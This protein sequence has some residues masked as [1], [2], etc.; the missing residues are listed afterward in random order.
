MFI[1]VSQAT[2]VTFTEISTFL[3]Y[4]PD[5]IYKYKSITTL[6]NKTITL[7]GGHLVY[8]RKSSDC[9]FNTV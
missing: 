6:W 8:T 5:A 7:T 4:T 1:V 3:K 2:T 9:K